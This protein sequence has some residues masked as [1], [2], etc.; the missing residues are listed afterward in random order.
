MLYS[1][2][3]HETW[4]LG[5]NRVDTGCNTKIRFKIQHSQAIFTFTSLKCAQLICVCMCHLLLHTNKVTQKEN[6]LS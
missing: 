4:A 2:G 3:F 5:S 6:T 1:T